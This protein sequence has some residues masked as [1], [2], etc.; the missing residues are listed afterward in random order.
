MFCCLGCFWC[1]CFVVDFAVFLGLVCFWLVLV[2]GFMG[3]LQVLFC[4]LVWRSRLHLDAFVVVVLCL[5]GFCDYC[6]RLVW[7][8]VAFVF[9]GF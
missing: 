7:C 1:S 9:C 3:V 6:L 2:L 4:G 5:F 8:F